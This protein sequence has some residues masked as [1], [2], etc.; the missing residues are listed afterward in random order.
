MQSLLLRTS[1]LVSMLLNEDI[2]DIEKLDGICSLTFVVDEFFV[3]I[4]TPI[5]LFIKNIQDLHK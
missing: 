3:I 4:L 5:N 2:V 1:C